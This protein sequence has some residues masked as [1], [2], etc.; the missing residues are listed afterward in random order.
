MNF[1]TTFFLVFSELGIKKFNFILQ[2]WFYEWFIVSRCFRLL[3]FFWDFLS[4]L[5]ED[6]LQCVQVDIIVWKLIHIP[7][8]HQIGVES[9]GKCMKKK[10]K[11]KFI[12]TST[13]SNGF[14]QCCEVHN[15]KSTGITN[16]LFCKVTKNLR[17]NVLAVWCFVG[18][19]LFTTCHRSVLL[20]SR[21]CF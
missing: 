13:F 2:D 5:N 3:K 15:S 8:Q 16:N 17:Y 19:N 1:L 18:S 10:A 21:S 4:H 12:S 7:K 9:D 20:K 14:L 11:Q 6:F